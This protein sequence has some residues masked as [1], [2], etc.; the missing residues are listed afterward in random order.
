MSYFNKVKVND[1][2]FSLVYGRGVVTMA[3][4]KKHRVD[5]FYIFSASYN[6]NKVV[7]YTDDGF[8][9]WCSTDGCVQT[10]FYLYD[11]DVSEMDIE[12]IC[13]VLSQKKIAKYQEKGILEIRCP[14]GIWRNVDEVPE[15]IVKKALKKDSYHIFRKESKK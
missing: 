13:T 2:V 4:P 10:V 12:P 14:S 11:V 3:L 8:P 9:D 6:N 5:G 1:E 7:H 15:K